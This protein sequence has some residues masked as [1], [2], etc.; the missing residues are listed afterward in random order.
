[1][2]WSTR[3]IN[4]RLFMKIFKLVLMVSALFL[5]ANASASLINLTVNQELGVN[6]TGGPFDSGYFSQ[7][8]GPD[9]TVGDGIDASGFFGSTVDFTENS[10]LIT[11]NSGHSDLPFNGFTYTFSPLVNITDVIFRD[12]SI[13]W[14]NQSNIFFNSNQIALDINGSALGYVQFDVMTSAVPEPSIIAL[15]LGGLGLLGFMAR[16]RKQA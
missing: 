1:M 11:F 10:G 4:K 16:R 9:F 5:S 12:S 14:F 13:D 8:N 2:C 3:A 7:I 6:L 15:M